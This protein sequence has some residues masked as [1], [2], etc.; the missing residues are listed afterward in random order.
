MAKDAKRPEPLYKPL[1][2]GNRG[3]APE[4]VAH[5]QRMRL[6]GAMLHACAQHGYAAVTIPELSRLASVSLRDFYEHFPSKEACFLATHDEAVHQGTARVSAAFRAQGD[7]RKGL[8]AAFDEYFAVVCDEPAAAELVIIEALT[9]GPKARDHRRQ[10][11]RAFERMLRESFDQ[12][13]PHAEVDDVTIGAIVAGTRRVVYRHLREGR[14]KELRQATEPIM[15]W[16]LLLWE[17]AKRRPL[18]QAPA[19]AG[20]KRRRPPPPPKSAPAQERI[21]AAIVELSVRDGYANV[22][23]PAIAKAARCSTQTF[24]K[25]FA[26]K[27]VAFTEALVAAQTAALGAIAPIL[28]ADVPWEQKITDGVAAILDHCARHP[29]ECELLL[30]REIGGPRSA[31]DLA[32]GAYASFVALFVPS[33]A[34][35]PAGFDPVLPEAVAGGLLH[36]AEERVALTGPAGLPAIAEQVVYLLQT[37]VFGLAGFAARPAAGTE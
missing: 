7:W 19:I 23:L 16:I 30:R 5:H 26:S 37:T 8:A 34:V 28:T 17:A 1:P 25:H 4:R 22:S 31:L 9:A 36:I 11:M 29:L 10:A 21:I 15:D 2:S 32:D 14:A 18:P 35:A 24:Y 27:D 20:G 6:M 3:I 13:R 12:A 33:A